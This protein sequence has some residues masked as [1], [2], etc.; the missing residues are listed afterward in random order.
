MFPNINS[1][2]FFLTTSFTNIDWSYYSISKVSIL[3]IID[4][5]I[6]AY[7]IYKITLWIKDTRARSLFKGIAII[8]VI[9]GL[10]FIFNL[11]TI[12]WLVDS[13]FN[14]GIIA[15]IVL[16][17]PELRKALEQIGKGKFSIPFNLYDE[18]IAEEDYTNVVEQILKA[19]KLLSNNRTGGLIIVEKS[20]SLADLEQTG[21]KIDGIV[22][23]PLLVNIFED[24]TPLHDGAV[25]I[26]GNRI[27]AAS[28]ILPLTT[29]EISKE[30]GTRHRAAVGTSEMYDAYAIVVSEETG[31]LNLAHEGK[32]LLDI[33]QDQIRKILLGQNDKPIKKKFVLWRMHN[34]KST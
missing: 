8:L 9:S 6:V 12:Y 20:I 11:T 33:S 10:S 30:L 1:S 2:I 7:F 23:A 32:L 16:F 17:Q 5:L 13:F 19:I 25:I 31:R 29:N 34:D 14:I 21:I 27:S 26:R 22:S 28:C 4:I 24:K 18:N 3:D 15:L